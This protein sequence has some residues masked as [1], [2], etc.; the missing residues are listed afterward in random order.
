MTHRGPIG[1]I[2]RS[3][4]GTDNADKPRIMASILIVDDDQAMRDML[5]AQLQ[6]AGYSAATVGSTDEALCLL[7]TEEFSAIVTD[8]QLPDRDGFELLELVKR[9]GWDVPVILMTAFASPATVRRA[10]ES[11]ASA[12]L[13][14]PFSG[15]ELLE[16][17]RQVVSL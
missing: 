11:G 13:A 3:S 1:P 10:R 2:F 5:A 4:A 8:L 14:K 9:E 12:C 15:S 17:V 16:T 7:A 6:Q